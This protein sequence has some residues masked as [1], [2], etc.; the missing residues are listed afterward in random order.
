MLRSTPSPMRQ[1]TATLCARLLGTLLLSIL[2][3]ACDSSTGK[4]RGADRAPGQPVLVASVNQSSTQARNLAAT[5][6]PRIGSDLGFRLNGKIA[7][8][9][10]QNGD[11]VR[12]GQPLLV[13]DTVDFQLQLEQGEAEVRAATTSL[14]QAEA[15]EA[16][17][18]TL[19]Q[20]AWS[21]QAMLDKAHAA[22]AE[23]RGPVTRAQ[24]AVELAHNAP[25]YAMLEAD[26]DGIITFTPV[27]PGHALPETFV[28]RARVDWAEAAQHLAN[29]TGPVPRQRE[30][31]RELVPEQV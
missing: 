14:A 28:E 6:R 26:A 16:R 5:I 30:K 2:V 13:L 20:K 11:L 29:G 24:C 10:V 22:A 25:I 12:K 23:A 7:R 1:A 18:T 17:T 3:A 27:E 19:E 15:D 9:L 4:D 31:T 8:R 21:P